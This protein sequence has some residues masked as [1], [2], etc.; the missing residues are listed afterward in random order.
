MELVVFLPIGH[1]INKEH[2]SRARCCSHNLSRMGARIPQLAHLN[3]LQWARVPDSLELASGLANLHLSA[4]VC[5]RRVC[6]LL[7]AQLV[8]AGRLLGAKL[9]LVPELVQAGFAYPSRELL[10]V[11]FYLRTIPWRLALSARRETRWTD[12]HSAIGFANRRAP[13]PI[14]AFRLLCPVQAGANFSQ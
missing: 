8:V 12:Q 1:L 5:G 9:E 10:P 14:R 3:L 6:V 4:R 7:R 11:R 2:L 13:K